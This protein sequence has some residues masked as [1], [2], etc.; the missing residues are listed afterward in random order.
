MNDNYYV[1]VYIDPRNY[2][3]FYYG[4]GK[5]N[6]KSSHLKDQSDSEKVKRINAIKKEG[7]EPIIKV[8][9]RDLSEKEAFLIEKTLI[10][11]LG[12]NL[13]NIASGHFADKFRPHDTYNLDLN[14]YDYKN[15]IYYVNVGEGEH[16]SWEDC[17]KFGFI[18]AGQ[19]PSWSDQIRTLNE[20]DVV[21]AYLKGKGYVGI[22]KIQNK[23]KRV[24]SF[25]Y[26]RKPLS[27]YDLVRPNIYKNSDN[28]NSEYLVKVKWIKSVPASEAKW[29]SKSDLYTTQLVKAS[30][31][32]LFNLKEK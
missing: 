21:V 9:A 28:K 27:S 26:K 20:G 29:K 16:R 30:F 32:R 5:G 19:S 18:A 6:R 13:T 12:R 10:W 8:I 23:A 25:K 14:G 22:G 11:K 31:P 7:L 4:K 15:G 1:Y 2:E 3:E 24:A 17:R